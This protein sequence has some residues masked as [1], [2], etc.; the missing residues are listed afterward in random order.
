MT[1]NRYKKADPLAPKVIT[2]QFLLYVNALI[3]LGFGVYLFIDMVGAHN[4]ASVIFL[5]SF[6]LLVNVGVMIFCAIT[7]GRRTPWAYYFSIFIVLVNAAFTQAGQFEVF[8]LLAFIF[9]VAILIFLLFMG[10]AY[11]KRS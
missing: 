7:I 11:L 6:F 1:K 9:D 8:D 10:R 5:I 2:A 4:T 3:W